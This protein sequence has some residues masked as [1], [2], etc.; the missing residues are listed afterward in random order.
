MNQFGSKQ[1]DRSL[2][3]GLFS[4]HLPRNPEQTFYPNL[5]LAFE[6]KESIAP[7]ISAVKTTVSRSLDVEFYNLPSP[8]SRR[9]LTLGDDES[10]LRWERISGNTDRSLRD[11]LALTS[12]RLPSGP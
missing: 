3:L 12:P 7:R 5:S 10:I 11:F 2:Q 9:L 8:G 1:P 4:V 6:P